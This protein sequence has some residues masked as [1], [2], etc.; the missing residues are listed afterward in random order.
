MTTHP[1]RDGA[2][3][4]LLIEI[5]P[6][7][8]CSSRLFHILHKIVTLTLCPSC[9]AFCGHHVSPGIA[10]VFSLHIIWC[11]KFLHITVVFFPRLLQHI[12]FLRVHFIF[13]PN[14][15][16]IL[17]CSATRTR[18][19]CILFL[20]FPT[21][22]IPPSFFWQVQVPYTKLQFQRF[23]VVH[24]AVQI[25]CIQI[26]CLNLRYISNVIPPSA[27]FSNASLSLL[28]ILSFLLL[29]PCTTQASPW[30]LSLLGFLLLMVFLFFIDYFIPPYSSSRP[31]ISFS[32]TAL[33]ALA[34][35]GA[36]VFWH[37]P[38]F[39]SFNFNFLTSLSVLSG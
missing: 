14:V 25:R 38:H 36:R 26:S 24:W 7:F 39:Y 9:F 6:T 2:P 1:F 30:A 21:P 13:S 35:A 10:I 33:S 19:L 27:F 4:L 32:H 18:H 28:C 16:F 23:R 11:C 34:M 22:G 15:S 37:S 31:H 17:F 5:C 29:L 20:L 12:S 8:R 3:F